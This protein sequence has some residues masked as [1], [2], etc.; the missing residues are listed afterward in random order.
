ML[1][2]CCGCQREVDAYLIGGRELYP[3]RSDLYDLP[4]WKC[5]T[6]GNYVGCH[7]KTADQTKPL[8]C[9]PTPAIRHA[10][11]RLHALIDP[12]WKSRLHSRKEIYAHITAAIGKQFHSA[13]IRSVEEA[14]RIYEIVQHLAWQSDKIEF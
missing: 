14:E 3:H 6:C 10:R 12:L 4:F 7:H 1:I 11:N 8:G 5:G 2:Y 13:E 9:I